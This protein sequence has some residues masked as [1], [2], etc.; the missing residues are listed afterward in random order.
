MRRKDLRSGSRPRWRRKV[1]CADGDPNVL[2]E[3]QPGL[4]GENGHPQRE[5]GLDRSL[6]ADRHSASP[7]PGDSPAG[8]LLD[9]FEGLFPVQHGNPPRL[10]ESVQLAR[11]VLPLRP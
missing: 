2:P 11:D 6:E 1:R 10:M 5:P 9:E 7:V 4:F 3:G 8:G